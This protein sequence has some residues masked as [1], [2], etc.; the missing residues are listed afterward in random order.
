VNATELVA[1]VGIYAGTFLVAAI[2]SVIPLIAI[3]VFL[4][5]AVLAL[6]PPPATLPLL[7]LLAAAGQLA[8]KLPIYYATRG[9][10]DLSG[11]HRAWLDRMRAWTARRRSPSLIL[12]VSAILGLPPFSL[13]A[14]AAGAL[15]IPARTFCAVVFAGRALRFAVIV[16]VAALAS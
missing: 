1:A 10:A 13:V 6:E 15:A 2:S 8:G 5:G 4:A 9:L 7:V 16:T 14:T 12:A 11:R 3:E